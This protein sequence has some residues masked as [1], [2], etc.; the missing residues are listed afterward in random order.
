MFLVDL[1]E[2]RIIDDIPPD[3]ILRPGP[4]LADGV[5]AVARRLYGH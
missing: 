1:E 4:R 5:V 2:G 3:L